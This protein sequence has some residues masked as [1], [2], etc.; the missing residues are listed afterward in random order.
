MLASVDVQSSPGRPQPTSTA[1]MEFPHCHR[2][3]CNNGT[4]AGAGGVA[5]GSDID[6]EV[7][8]GTLET[9]A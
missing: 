9:F 6:L 3:I 1:L 4:A 5:G 7:V 2:T 8:W